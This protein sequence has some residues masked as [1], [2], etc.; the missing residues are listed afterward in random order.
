MSSGI[1]SEGGEP[2]LVMMVIDDQSGQ[3]AKVLLTMAH[4]DQNTPWM[5]SMLASKG[6]VG[7]PIGGWIRLV[8]CWRVVMGSAREVDGQASTQRTRHLHQIH[9]TC[10]PACRL[11]TEPVPRRGNAH[12]WSG[13]GARQAGC[14]H[15]E[16]AGQGWSE[17]SRFCA[18]RE[19]E[20]SHCRHRSQAGQFFRGARH[21]T[22]ARLRGD[23]RRT[24]RDQQQWQRLSA[25][26][27][28]RS[29]S[30]G[31]A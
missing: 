21:A 31:G 24:L 30:A 16:S 7:L 25:S 10:H 8:S 9:H 11:A 17:T 19:P 28:H 5:P 27:P 1:V 20:P 29:H 18:L 2:E 15:Q 26:R 23:A 3:H 12:G 14:T 13:D 6:T 4:Q 22:G